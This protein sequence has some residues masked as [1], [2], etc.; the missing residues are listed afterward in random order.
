MITDRG[1]IWLQAF[2]K[3]FARFKFQKEQFLL[4]FT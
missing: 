2:L 1:I 4:I 3:I